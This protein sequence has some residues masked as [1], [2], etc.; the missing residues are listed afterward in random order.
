MRNHDNIEKQNVLREGKEVFRSEIIANNDLVTD[1]FYDQKS[2]KE[3][4]ISNRAN[5]VTYSNSISNEALNYEMELDN[6][7][8]SNNNNLWIV[9][10]DNYKQESSLDKETQMGHFK[11]LTYK[12]HQQKSNPKAALLL[13][14]LHANSPAECG[15]DGRRCRDITSESASTRQSQ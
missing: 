4:E 2:L 7:L 8:K 5:S 9:G 11:N 3:L 13:C 6:I 12:S 10:I 14:M 15:L 1:N